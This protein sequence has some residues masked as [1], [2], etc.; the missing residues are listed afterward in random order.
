[1]RAVLPGVLLVMAS[2]IIGACSTG[3][4]YAGG[5]SGCAE[6]RRVSADA[7]SGIIT[8]VELRE[9]MKKVQSRTSTA[10]PAINV[11]ATAMLAGLTAGDNDAFA[12]GAIAMFKAC[13]E[14]G[15]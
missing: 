8:D 5:S 1:M 10:E 15:Y 11:A 12:E 13:D 2:L 4:A 3:S 6:F 7:A 9:K 14:N